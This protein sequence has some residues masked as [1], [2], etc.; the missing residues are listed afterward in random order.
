MRSVSL[1]ALHWFSMIYHV[2]VRLAN[3]L[4]QSACLTF[5]EELGRL[6]LL[7]VGLSCPKWM[8]GRAPMG[9]EQFFKDLQ[10]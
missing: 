2:D 4:L 10:Q 7:L 6:G 3:V 5:C 9:V 8:A 1:S